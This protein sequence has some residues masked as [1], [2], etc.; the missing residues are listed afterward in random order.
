MIYSNYFMTTNNDSWDFWMLAVWFVMGL[1]FVVL[2]YVLP[3]IQ[4]TF[5]IFGGFCFVMFVIAIGF[6]YV[7]DSNKKIIPFVAPVLVISLWLTIVIPYVITIPT[8]SI[9]VN[10]S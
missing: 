2:S 6:E 9:Y 3:L 8:A 5:R 7:K 10:Q 1:I 4:N